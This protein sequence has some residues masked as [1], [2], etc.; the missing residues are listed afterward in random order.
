MTSP[1]YYIKYSAK[2]YLNPPPPEIYKYTVW[3]AKSDHILQLLGILA[4]K[5]PGAKC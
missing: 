4:G 3:K 2:R 1:H 5:H